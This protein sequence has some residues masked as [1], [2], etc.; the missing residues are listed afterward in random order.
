MC[1]IFKPVFFISLIPIK[2]GLGLLAY[3]LYLIIDHIIKKNNYKGQVHAFKIEDGYDSSG[4]V[5]CYY[6]LYH[7]NVSNITYVCKSTHSSYISN[8][9]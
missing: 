4:N 3:D 6:P 2:V 8:D 7:F 5:K 9:H 1:E